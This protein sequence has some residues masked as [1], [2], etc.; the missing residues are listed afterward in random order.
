M[1]RLLNWGVDGII[2][3]Y[4][5]RLLKLLSSS[6]SRNRLKT[7]LHPKKT[8]LPGKATK[9]Q[10]AIHLEVPTNGGNIHRHQAG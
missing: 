7:G 9:F 2:T 10:Q 5:D 8:A 3:D 6:S 4:P 1:Q